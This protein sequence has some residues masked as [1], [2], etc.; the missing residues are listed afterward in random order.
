MSAKISLSN[1]SEIVLAKISP[2]RYIAFTLLIRY[3]DIRS[4]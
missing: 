1:T 2:V 3:A 4:P